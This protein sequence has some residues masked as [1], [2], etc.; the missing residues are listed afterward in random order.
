MP[1]ILKS[2]DF[3][4]ADR[5]RTVSIMLVG[6]YAL[7]LIAI[8]GTSPDGMRD[9]RDIPLGSDFF[10]FWTAGRMAAESGAADAYDPL[11]NFQMQQKLLNDTDPFFLPFLHPPQ[12][13]FVAISLAALP[14]V[15]AWLTFSFST[16]AGYV[17][18]MSKLATQKGALL[19][20]ITA[21]PAFLTFTHGQTGFLI[22]SLFAAA[23]YFLDKRPLLAGVFIG[24][25]AFK[26]QYGIFFPLVLLI[27]GRWR[28]IVAA[29]STVIA[30]GLAATLAFGPTI[31]AS[32]IEKAEYAR[33]AVL[34]EGG[35]KWATNQS[36]YSAM[37]AFGA[38]SESAYA[39]QLAL[40]L[41]L[42]A[43]L[44]I[45][46]RSAAD[47]RLKSAALI[48]AAF[49]ATPYALHY[50]FI[51]LA[52]AVALFASYCS[53]CGFRPY[54]KL[55]LAL[56]WAV[57]M[58]AMPFAEATLIPVGLMTTL[59]LYALLMRRL[60]RA[61]ARTPEQTSRG[62]PREVCSNAND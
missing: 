13:L 44:V 14:Y 41:S 35:V 32:F 46:W 22:A 40:A 5:I 26:P 45:F 51:M 57:P 27:A 34:E 6:A 50:D 10:S 42:A 17:A 30:Q 2:G 52:P 16:L 9:F 49:L 11:L 55:M 29:A 19:A 47:Q 38:S 12:F 39:A 60:P 56:V 54:E 18:A 48:V 4:T 33:T 3:L 37:R 15:A 28:T 59:A 43:S 53:E 8:I 23:L 1:E 24:L 58:V 25:L 62:L 7:A 36:L 21:P 20:I 61:A 31:W